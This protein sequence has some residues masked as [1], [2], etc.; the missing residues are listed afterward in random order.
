MIVLT[1]Y[2]D[3]LLD[4]ILSP[5]IKVYFAVSVGVSVLQHVVQVQHTVLFSVDLAQRFSISLSTRK[6]N[7]R[8]IK[9]SQRVFNLKRHSF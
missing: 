1:I 3:T 8:N 4:Q 5:F 7:M 2:G 9:N 6:R